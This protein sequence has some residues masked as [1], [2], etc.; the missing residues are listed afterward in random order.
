[1]RAPLELSFQ[2]A[3]RHSA[4]STRS[5]MANED[6]IIYDVAE[7][8]VEEFGWFDIVEED[9]G[10]NAP[11]AT[12]NATNRILRRNTGAREVRP[13]RFAHGDRAENITNL[14]MSAGVLED[15]H[16][17]VREWYYNRLP[18]GTFE[19]PFSRE[20]RPVADLVQHVGENIFQPWEVKSDREGPGGPSDYR[21]VR[22]S[23]QQ[24]DFMQTYTDPELP[25]YI[26]YQF[27]ATNNRRARFGKYRK[28]ALWAR[29]RARARRQ[30]RMDVFM[31]RRRPP[32]PPPPEGNALLV[33]P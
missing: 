6:D 32:S 27:D 30:E 26:V 5:I 11:N 15:Y 28:R 21:T 25:S 20:N 2:L 16:E 13:L 1:M 24:E 7:E 3:K 14:F 19:V 29:A 10:V 22:G 8:P 18:Y 9:L 17:P 23:Q 31:P 12:W 4:A 33:N